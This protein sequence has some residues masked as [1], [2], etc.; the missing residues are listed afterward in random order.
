MRETGVA[1][2]RDDLQ[3][4]RERGG[5]EFKPHLVVAFAGRAVGDG[6]G[7]FLLGDFDHALGDERAGDAGA[8]EILVLIN[9]ARLHHREK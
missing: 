4:R 9:R 6:V 8:E 3:I 1:P 7:F 5:G 2:R